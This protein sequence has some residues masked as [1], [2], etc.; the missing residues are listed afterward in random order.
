M[1]QVN[2]KIMKNLQGSSKV[3]IFFLNIKLLFMDKTKQ[4][5]FYIKIKMKGSQFQ[6]GHFK[7]R[8]FVP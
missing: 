1:F 3:T 2:L 6:Y 4:R 7:S 8:C 5:R